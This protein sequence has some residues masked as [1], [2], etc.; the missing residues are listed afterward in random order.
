VT[1]PRSV[2]EPV[3]FVAS[4]ALTLSVAAV[5]STQPASG[6]EEPGAADVFVFAPG[7]P[8]LVSSPI[9]PGEIP[10]PEKQE[11][12]EAFRGRAEPLSPV[13][14]VEL[15]EL[16]GFPD[17]RTAWAVVMKESTGDPAAH[18]GN[19]STGDSSYGLFQINMIDSLGV[20]R[21]GQFGL[22]TDDELFDPV[23]NAEVAFELSRGGTDFGPWGV[24]PNA[25]RGSR[26]GSYP[27]WYRD[28][29][30]GVADE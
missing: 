12:I 19:R 20:A 14:L 26:L 30:G 22:A 15:L 13:E 27:R 5:V 28:F 2:I 23:L 10:V 24:G 8:V 7:D 9:E 4:L 11:P 21:R 25:Y 6:G 3:V 18:N 29:P 1:A 17:V 16:V